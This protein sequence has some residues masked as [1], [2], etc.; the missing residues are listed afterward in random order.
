MSAQ[1]ALTFVNSASFADVPASRSLWLSEVGITSPDHLVDFETGFVDGQ[2]I[3]GT[4]GLFPDGLVITDT[5]S[6]NAANVRSGSVIGG[7][8]PV[9]S[10]ALTHNEGAFLVLDFAASPV[11]YFSFRDIDTTS[12]SIR[13]NF[14]GGGFETVVSETTGAS[15]D[16]AEFV[17]VFRNDQARIES[18]QLD[19]NGDGTWGID[20]IEYGTIPEPSGASMIVLSLAALGRR[21]R[22]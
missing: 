12:T 22:K 16:S 15:G 5:T 18:V 4:T 19:A 8:N 7:S 20:N 13:V 1:A 6:S 11:D 14:V 2:N 17:G 21:R 10:F 3:S 9:G